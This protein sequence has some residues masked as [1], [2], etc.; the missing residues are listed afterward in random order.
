MLRKLT[1]LAGLLACLGACSNQPVTDSAGASVPTVLFE[2]ARLIPGDGSAP[3]ENAAFI[4]A[5]GTISRIGKKGELEVPSGATRVDLTGKTVMPTLISAHVHPGFQKGLSYA[6]EN[7]TRATV[8]NDLNLALYYG[9]AAVMSQGIERGDIS[10]EIRSE[11]EAGRLGGARL[12]I[13]GRGIGAPNAGPGAAAYAG[14]A[15]EVVNEAET[16]RAVQE[17]AARKVNAVKIWVDDR[18]GRA[19]RLSPA[20]FSAAIDEGHKHALRVSAHIFYHA[21]AVELVDAGIDS[22]AHLV[23][24]RVMDD[25]LIAA[26]T[27]RNVYVMP[28]LG[29]AERNTHTATPAWMDEPYLLGLLTDTVS[30]EAIKRMRTLFVGRDAAMIEPMRRNYANMVA[31]LKKLSAAG[32]RIILGCD[33]G[34]PDH[35]FGYAEQRELELMVSAG[36][37]PAQVIVAATSRPAEYLGLRDTGSLTPGKRADFLVL[38]ANPLEDIRNTRR[39]AKIYIKGAEINRAALREG[40]LKQ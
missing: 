31:S 14:I 33:T 29:G 22:F 25:A 19:P 40:L 1:L 2:G 20:L 26:V 32:A 27:R 12:L 15:Y 28:N 23:R 5:R 21:D 7:Y 18:G 6:S 37:T 39:I 10:Y 8:V 16:R 36:M 13:A 35:F 11:Q 30:P 34:L 38:D 9:V 3:I 4:V 17:L 24:D